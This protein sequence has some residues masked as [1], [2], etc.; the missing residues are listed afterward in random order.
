MLWTTSLLDHFQKES[1]S[2]VK[3]WI[4]YRVCNMWAKSAEHVRYTCK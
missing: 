2:R 1:K 3:F 4:Q